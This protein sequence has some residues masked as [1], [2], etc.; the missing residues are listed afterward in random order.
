M[1]AESKVGEG[2]NGQASTQY[3]NSGLEGLIIDLESGANDDLFNEKGVYISFAGIEGRAIGAEDDNGIKFNADT[4]A[5][6][7]KENAGSFD[8]SRTLVTGVELGTN[9]SEDAQI[10]TKSVYDHEKGTVQVFAY[11]H[12]N[13]SDADMVAKSEIYNVR[14]ADGNAYKS[15][16]IILSEVR[17]DDDTAGTGLGM[18]LSFEDYSF[19]DL[20]ASTELKGD[21]T[22]TNIG[23]RIYSE[24]YGSDA[25][26][27][28]NQSQGGIFTYYDT[29]GDNSSQK[30]LDAESK[31]ITKEFKGQ[32]ATL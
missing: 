19:A 15:M 26:V 4:I 30:L 3:N 21:M 7:G 17:N 28:V 5:D 27:K 23:A 9:T 24:E 1:S 8:A 32:D 10:F 12:R 13:M 25:I 6:G 29:A 11:K 31:G 18:V 22:F 14:D 2:I 16:S 20:T